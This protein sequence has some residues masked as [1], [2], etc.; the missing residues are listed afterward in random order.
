[1][2]PLHAARLPDG[3]Y[4]QDTFRISYLPSLRLLRDDVAEVRSKPLVHIGLAV[5]PTGDL[6]FA[7]LEA[8]LVVERGDWETTDVRP[9][10]GATVG[11]VVELMESY[12]VFHFAGH[13]FYDND[14][15]LHSGLICASRNDESEVLSLRTLL[16]RASRIKSRLLVLSACETGRIEAGDV[17]D[18]FLGLPG[19]CL[20][21]GADGVVSSL[22]KV[23]DRATCVLVAKFTELWDQR[24]TS[25]REAL[26][27][28]Q[29]W[30]RSATAGE[31]ADFFAAERARLEDETNEALYERA[32][33][34]WRSFATAPDPR[35]APFSHP[36]HWAA[37][38]FTGV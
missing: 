2:L 5:D 19:G 38:A 23:D 21:A 18:D 28:A 17:L 35:S 30:L 31:L 32:S 12:P 26:A 16:D 3:R 7:P 8:K 25:V 33:D 15:P 37:F 29:K 13:G 9:G 22:W 20:V 34:A 4:A 36:I 11:G 1:L 24:L 27:G 10:V 6:P 14:E